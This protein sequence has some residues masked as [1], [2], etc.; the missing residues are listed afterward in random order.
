VII[1]DEILRQ[2]RYDPRVRPA[3]ANKTGLSVTDL[4][5]LRIV[6]LF[7]NIYFSGTDQRR[8]RRVVPTNFARF[9]FGRQHGTYILGGACADT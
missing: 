3:A 5:F 1:L 4:N 9:T 7:Q 2:D 6:K 8:V